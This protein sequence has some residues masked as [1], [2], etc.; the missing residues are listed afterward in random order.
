MIQKLWNDETG[1]VLSAEIILVLTILICGLVIGWTAVR[2]AITTELA[3]VGQAVGS[4]NQSYSFSGVT[5][6]H[7]TCV[8]SRFADALDT[9]DDQCAQPQQANSRCV[10]ICSI[11]AAHEA[12]NRGTVVVVPGNGVYP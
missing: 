5:G 11:P 8:G 12:D 4:L 7:A 6:H 1:A 10:L 3:D 2:D 9:C